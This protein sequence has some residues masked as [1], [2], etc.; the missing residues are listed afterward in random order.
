MI[1]N[2]TGEVV[3]GGDPSEMAGAKFSD[4]YVNYCNCYD[5]ADLNEV[6]EE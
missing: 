3:K 4:V 6:E 1:V 2:T 5:I